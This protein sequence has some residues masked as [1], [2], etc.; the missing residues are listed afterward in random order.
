MTVP[1][2]RPHRWLWGAAAVAALATTTTFGLASQGIDVVHVAPGGD[3]ASL[4]RSHRGAVLVLDAGRHRGFTL[5]TSVTV[6]GAPGS[7][8]DGPIDVRAPRV[9][10]EDLDLHRGGV[11]VRDVD[12]VVIDRVSVTGADTRG[13]EV[14]DASAR[15]SRCRIHGLA[16]SYA[17][18][19]AVRNANSRPHTVVRNCTVSG[20][21]EGIVAHVS[22]V[23][24]TGNHVSGTTLRA[25]T[26]TEMSEGR[27][28]GNTVRHVTGAGVW[29]GDMSHCEVRDNRV[30][31]VAAS[32]NGARSSGGHGIAAGFHS[33]LRAESNQ[34]DD[35]AGRPVAL[36]TD[37][38]R[39][40]RFP[41][42]MW[43]PGWRGALPAIPITLGAVAGLAVLAQ[44]C[45]A[46]LA[47]HQRRPEAASQRPARIELFAVVTVVGGFLVQSFHMLEHVVQVWQT[48]AAQAQV[49]S[50]LLGAS[51]DVEWVHLI[52]NAAVLAFLVQV[53]RLGRTQGWLAG[54]GGA[55][56]WTL[57][58]LVLQSY[59]LVEHIARVVQYVFYGVPHPRGLLGQVVDLTWLHFGINTA[60]WVATLVPVVVMVRLATASAV[61]DR[62]Q[63]PKLSSR[64]QWSTS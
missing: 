46:V 1:I 58:A 28:T 27:V 10:L 14:V 23:E 62:A 2:S 49:R 61:A 25:I 26:V 18:G 39:T 53:W 63:R 16:S 24:F 13:I 38:S 60:V 48:F 30:S 17:M 32:D 59:H 50:G 15:I 7:R 57:A 11:L 4:A 34:I 9:R 33:I 54:S 45:K 31:A 37:S 22:R 6:R 40:D 43:P 64:P 56:A 5:R 47:R 52:F 8:V 19:I 21:Q 36:F 29:C 12:G 3:V 55:A 51:L 44:L 41:L 35:V 42:M 20:G